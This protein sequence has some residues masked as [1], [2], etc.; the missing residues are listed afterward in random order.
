[1]SCKLNRPAYE[2]MIAE[3]IEWLRKLPN[4]SSLGLRHIIEVVQDSTRCYYDQENELSALRA[5]V[6]RVKGALMVVKRDYEFRL[7]RYG[8]NH[9]SFQ[10]IEVVEAALAR[11]EQQEQERCC[12]KCEGKGYLCTYGYDGTHENCVDCPDC[13]GTGKPAKE[14]SE[15][16]C[17][18][19]LV[20]EP[21]QEKCEVCG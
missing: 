11:P 12:H 18:R 4:Q 10:V 13:H 8:A 19:K 14:A 2:R 3:D 6:E 1:M 5:E 16:K 15:C 7:N 9:V 20:G 21:G 17:G